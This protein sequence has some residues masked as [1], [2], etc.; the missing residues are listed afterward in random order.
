MQR[1]MRMK[2]F[3]PECGG[4]EVCWRVRGQVEFISPW[5]LRSNLTHRKHDSNIVF[6]YS[7]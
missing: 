6:D 7:Q 4:E 1:F 2:L 5:N 3:N